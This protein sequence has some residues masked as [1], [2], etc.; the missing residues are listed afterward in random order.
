MDSRKADEIARAASDLVTTKRRPLLFLATYFLAVIIVTGLTTIPYVNHPVA[1]PD[2]SFFLE[3]FILLLLFLPWG[4]MVGVEWILNLV[5]IHAQLIRTEGPFPGPSNAL[6]GWLGIS[7][8]LLFFM[9][10]VIG[11]TTRKQR[12][13]RIL[14]LV[15]IGLLLINIGG[16]SV[17]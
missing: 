10:A 1:R 4:V 12:T 6:G 8:Y 2:F 17:A 16:C 9:I 14:Y 5:G 7:D 11:S 13:F 15:F 3:R